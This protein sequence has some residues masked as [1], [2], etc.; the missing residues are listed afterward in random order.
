MRVFSYY[1]SQT[2]KATTTT[3][4]LLLK[5]KNKSETVLWLVLWCSDICLLGC[6]TNLNIAF[7]FFH[8][9]YVINVRLFVVVVLIKFY[10]LDHFQWCHIKQVKMKVVYKFLPSQVQTLNGCKIHWSDQA[11]SDGIWYLN[12]W[13]ISWLQKLWCQPFLRYC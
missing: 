13:C 8:T 5:N 7:V 11:H 9:I 12:V 4:W 6:D 2:T 3:L 10:L 1:Y